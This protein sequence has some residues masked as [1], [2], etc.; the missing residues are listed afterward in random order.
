M[1]LSEG[2]RQTVPADLKSD[3]ASRRNV[4]GLTQMKVLRQVEIALEYPCVALL[5]HNWVALHRG[6]RQGHRCKGIRCRGT[7]ERFSCAMEEFP[8][9]GLAQRTPASARRV[10]S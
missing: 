6:S 1:Q 2:E 8:G 7:Y 10:V 3:P 9:S 5:Q 4:Y